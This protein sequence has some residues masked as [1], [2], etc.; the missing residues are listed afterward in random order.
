MLICCLQLFLTCVSSMSIHYN[1]YSQLTISDRAA[2]T[3][4][5][6]FQNDYS[7]Q[8]SLSYSWNHLQLCKRLQLNRQDKDVETVIGLQSEKSLCCNTVL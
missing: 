2:S 7:W 5:L 8:R 4:T 3:K 6:L 1:V